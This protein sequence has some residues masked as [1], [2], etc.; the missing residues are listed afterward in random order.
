[1]SSQV[2]LC[3]IS[4]IPNDTVSGGYIGNQVLDSL[5]WAEKER[6]ISSNH[7]SLVPYHWLEQLP[8]DFCCMSAG[9]Q[10]NHQRACDGWVEDVTPSQNDNETGSTKRAARKI[11]ITLIA[12]LSGAFYISIT[13]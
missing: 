13:T 6:F 5:T 3:V 11:L 1:M 2:S 9:K 7:A 8:K 4:G 10:E 12:T